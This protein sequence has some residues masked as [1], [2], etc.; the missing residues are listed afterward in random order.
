MEQVTLASI[1]RMCKA[2]EGGSVR[3]LIVLF[4]ISVFAV[5]AGV[6]AGVP[7][8]AQMELPRVES[9]RQ[10]THDGISKL[11]LLADDSNLYITEWPSGRHVLAKIVLRNNARSVISTG[12]PN[13]EALDISA[14]HSKLLIAPT[15]GNPGE[16]EF[17]VLPTT[18][19][20]PVRLAQLSGRDAAWSVDGQKLVFAKGT[21]LYVSDANGASVRELFKADESIFA[22]RV[23][24]DNKVVRFTVSNAGQNSTVLWQV[25]L[26][27][28]NPHP[29]LK[30][31]QG[32]SGAC[33]GNWS[34]DGRYFIFQVTQNRP[35]ALTTLWALS[36][37]S[38]V[39]FQ[40]TTGPISFGN[41]LPSRDNT[42]IWAIGVMPAGEAV[43][44]DAERKKFI[45]L[46]A[47]V[48]ATDLDYSPDRK[49]VAY[50]SIPDGELYRCRPDGTE[51]LRLTSAPE[52]AALPRWSK[53]L[54]KIAYVRMMPGK[55]WRIS[56]ISVSGGHSQ[57]ILDDQQGQIDANWSPDGSRI[58]F[59]YVYGSKH[60]AIK[61]LNLKTNKVEV[62]PGSEGLFSP[63]WSPD[64]RYIAA[65]T[66]DF[67]KVKLFDFHSK[68]WSTW[69]TEP[70]GAVS[71]PVWS[72]DS[73]SVFFDD[74]VTDEES[75]RRVNVGE[76]RTQRVF[77]LE[78]IE[79]YPG[80]FGLWTG[81]M[82][83]GS[84]MFVRDH[85][86]QEVYQLN[87]ALPVVAV[88]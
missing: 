78:G 32:A 27:G 37:A 6:C 79:R 30:N 48:S 18:T 67:S 10:I 72:A 76:H 81:R 59:G 2:S 15:Q 12:F 54:S 87:L 44:Y 60:L 36:G 45:P 80:M 29:L 7:R 34:A 85:S 55:P 38:S 4:S 33:C 35:T 62:V 88:K 53:D 86:T 43:K 28:S 64:G 41:P 56:I 39:P 26:D 82:P 1:V 42:K 19:G 73:K 52:R 66:P 58:L 14:D 31:W 74:L 8:K 47:G 20:S 11:N 84:W 9:I 75:I 70:A 46:L 49:W 25:N 40:L 83:D 51:M 17:W 21:T 65:L 61:I 16:N 24:P 57:D 77:K 13:V 50:V 3:G 22:P 23:S 69:L 63:R 5:V 68:R 71:Y